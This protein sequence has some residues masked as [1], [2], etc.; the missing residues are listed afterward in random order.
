MIKSI[1]VL[2]QY[3]SLDILEWNDIPKLSVITGVNGSGKNQLLEAIY[4]EIERH[5][6]YTPLPTTSP[7]LLKL[8]LTSDKSERVLFIESDWTA[9]GFRPASRNIIDIEKQNLVNSL[10]EQFLSPTIFKL[11]KKIES[12]YKKA[13]KDLTDQEI[14][15]L[16]PDDFYINQ[17]MVVT[18]QHLS[19]LFVNYLSKQKSLFLKYSDMPEN[20]SKKIYAIKKMVLGEIGEQPWKKINSLLSENGFTHQVTYPED[21]S[22]NFNCQFINDKNETFSFQELSSGEQMIVNLILWSYNDKLSEINDIILMDEPDAHLHP[23]MSKLFYKI[24]SE[25]LVDKY[26]IQVIM[27][28]H[29]PSTVALLPEDNIFI[30]NKRGITPRIK[31]ADSK[32]KA[33]SLLTENL[34]LVTSSFKLVIVEDTDDVKFYEKVFEFL[35][36][37]NHLPSTTPLVFKPVSTKKKGDTGGCN[38]VKTLIKQ[39]NEINPSDT[40]LGNLFY[41]LIDKDDSNTEDNK[42]FVLNRYSIENYLFDPILVFAHLLFHVRPEAEKIISENKLKIHNTSDIQNQNDSELQLIA[43]SII[44]LIK[45]NLPEIND[46]DA[47]DEEVT[48]ITGQKLK[49][50]KYLI[51]HK[52]NEFAAT[53]NK[54]FKSAGIGIENLIKIIKTTGLIPTDLRD[55]MEEIQKAGEKL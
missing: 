38:K 14:S 25:E 43:N 29:N 17:N 5:N 11:K 52:G 3:K 4:K 18:N 53:Y 8:V 34:L 32:Q 40:T 2:K 16:I 31:K 19:H 1:K 45:E 35:V 23:S 49:Y 36:A 12:H 55:K 48:F 47:E 22:V 28:T 50:P 46:K 9:Q 33:L 39:L 24:V 30:M 21:D 10:K 27:T 26:K 20:C 51:T 13:I 44:E 41:G 15:Q 6:N 54:T 42:L 7:Q 37:Y